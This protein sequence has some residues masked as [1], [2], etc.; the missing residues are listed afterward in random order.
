MI[1]NRQAS[2]A[3]R[4]RRATEILRREGYDVVSHPETHPLPFDLEGYQPDLIATRGDE[5]LV[6][7]VR[8]S[9]AHTS[10]DR[11]RAIAETV[12][13]HP[14]WRFVLVTVEDEEPRSATEEPL[15]PLTWEEVLERAKSGQEL[16]E[17]GR[18]DAALLLLWTAF[19]AALRRHAAD[20]RIPAERMPVSILLKHLYSS[21]ELSVEHF[22]SANRFLQAR[23]KAFHGF[24]TKD[25]ERNARE[26][27]ELLGQVL[28]EWRSS[29]VGGH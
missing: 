20:E 24:Q 13:S 10:I 3:E 21:G 6:V 28:A 15:R 8:E 27:G 26:L 11:Y 7:E 9:A 17:S 4:E 14:G 5:K 25:L 22:E 1:R 23:N 16:V 29:G 2:G 12:G 18:G 19:E